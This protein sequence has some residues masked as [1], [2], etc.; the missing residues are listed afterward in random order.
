MRER[1]RRR[2]RR[3]ARVS[4]DIFRAGVGH[5]ARTRVARPRAAVVR[6]LR[7]STPPSCNWKSV[8][9]QKKTRERR[10]MARAA[11][12]SLSL[13]I[14]RKGAP[15]PKLRKRPRLTSCFVFFKLRVRE[16]RLYF[17]VGTSR[18]KSPQRRCAVPGRAG[19]RTR[20]TRR[21]VITIK[22]NKYFVQVKE[23]VQLTWF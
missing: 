19:A 12:I 2:A 4:R 10:K 16:S 14:A 15:V 13:G 5:A 18:R 23:S 6:G 1:A 20:R 7:W 8:T 9:F 3:R 21:A 22:V 17:L 11:S